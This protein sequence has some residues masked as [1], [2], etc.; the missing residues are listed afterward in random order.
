[1]AGPH[2]LAHDLI[3]GPFPSDGTLNNPHLSFRDPFVFLLHSNVD[4]LWAMWQTQP[5]QA[6]RV[7]PNQ[8]YG[9]AGSDPSINAPL[10]PWAGE[11]GWQMNGH[12]P[13][14]PW[15]SP[16]N[17]QV[18]KTSK[19]LSVVI[20]PCYDTLPTFPTQMTLLT[21]SLIFNDVPAGETAARAIVLSVRSCH[22]VTLNIP[23]APTLFSV[24]AGTNFTVLLG[25]SVTA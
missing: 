22:D 14:R 6:W 21:P 24:P 8:V 12:W 17:L 3:G 25:T 5:G 19:D 23:P 16:E 9:S 2:G 13:V 1:M 4:R 7:D 11:N 10:Q 18:T 20:P 15:Y